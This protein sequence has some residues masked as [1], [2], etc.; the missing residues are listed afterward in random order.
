MEDVTGFIREKGRNCKC[1]G[2]WKVY[3]DEE[4]ALALFS[5]FRKCTQIYREYFQK[6]YSLEKLTVIQ[7]NS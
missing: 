3:G 2:M 1:C 5:R 7:N 6:G 4:K